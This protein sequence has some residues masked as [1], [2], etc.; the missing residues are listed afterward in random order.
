[1]IEALSIH[2]FRCF[3]SLKFRPPSGVSFVIGANAQGKTSILEAICVG[4]RLQSPRAI[5][6]SEVIRSGQPG[7]AVDL[8]T[9]EN[10]LHLRY[11]PP[12]RRLAVNSSEQSGT[13]EYLTQIRVAW[14]SN[15]DIEIVRGSGSRRRRYLDFVCCQLEPIY[16]KYLRAYE[17]ALRARNALLKDGKPRREIEAFDPLVIENGNAITAIRGDVCRLLVPFV[18]IAANEIGASGETV[19]MAYESTGELRAALVAS[20]P[21]ESR[22]RQT[23]VGPHR[24]DIIIALNQQSAARFA[25]EGQQRTLALALKL[26]QTRLIMERLDVVPVL[27]VDDVFGEL[28]ISRRRNLLRGLPSAAQCIITTTH[29]DW[30]DDSLRGP[31]FQL[32]DA[33]LTEFER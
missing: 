16:L 17:R 6:L 20:H 1:V 13:A 23:V 28:D 7:T 21:D 10:H 33:K 15:D 9:G 31:V 4:A 14:F 12:K 25:S 24:D 19:E 29:L 8:W 22:V 2:D 18:Q 30:M 26:A 11:E 32:K 3:E 27:L 5:G